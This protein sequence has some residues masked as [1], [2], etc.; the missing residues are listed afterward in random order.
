MGGVEENPESRTAGKSLR[1]TTATWTK[2]RSLPCTSRTA[3]PCSPHG[4]PRRRKTPGAELVGAPRPPFALEVKRDARAAAAAAFG[5]GGGVWLCCSSP[6]GLGGAAPPAL[7]VLEPWEVQ[8]RGL[9]RALLLPAPCPTTSASTACAM[10]SRA[11]WRLCSACF[12]NGAQGSFIRLI[13]AA[14]P[15]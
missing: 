5:R 7:E 12:P 2:P 15:S 13:A 14:S 4:H 3:T 6:S 10:A 11:S 1:T 8:L 9:I